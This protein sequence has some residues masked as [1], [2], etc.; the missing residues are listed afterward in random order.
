MLPM[1]NAADYSAD[2]LIQ[3]G[4]EGRPNN[5]S[6][7]TGATGALGPGNNEID[8][9]VI[10]ADEATRILKE[11]GVNVLRVNADE[12]E[13]N[14][15]YVQVAISIHFDGRT[16]LC[17]SGAHIGF[18]DPADSPAAQEWKTLYSTHWPYAWLEDNISKNVSQYY[19]YK[20]FE[21]KDSEFLMELGE[22]SCLEQSE[23]FKPRLKWL[24]ALTAHFLSKRIGIGNVPNPGP[25]TTA[26]LDPDFYLRLYADLQT[27]FGIEGYGP[28]Y[29]HWKNNG[30]N[31]GRI[32]SPTF[33]VRYY[34]SLFP[35]LQ[36]AF[37]ND[38]AA[39]ERHWS[40]A[41]IKEGRR[42]SPVFDVKYYL[43][44]YPDL[45]NAFGN[46]YAAA[47]Q[48]WLDAGIREGRRG[49]ADFDPKYY[50]QANP[51]VAAAYGA[52]NYK[53]AMVHWLGAGRA[54]GRKG[55]P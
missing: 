35:D 4:H 32:G 40:D 18:E 7:A 14:N 16:S 52:T 36:N 24:G 45:Q 12:I 55:V 47:V 31:E 10:I 23:W 51:D 13:G 22:I 8:W 9:T 2:V 26:S 50:L 48:H 25:F 37:G 44:T 54:E 39:A 29:L 11:A 34:L 41:G 46:D 20:N 53:G 3:A 21:A 33:D 43:G 19:G 6:T 49:S 15:Y 1:A 38:Y 17:S 42:S 27:A 30:I 28:A 5:S